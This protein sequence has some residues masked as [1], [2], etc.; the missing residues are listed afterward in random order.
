MNKHDAIIALYSNVSKVIDG[1]AYNIAGNIV[2][3]DETAVQNKLM[4]MQAQAEQAEQATKNAKAS[5]L[6]KLTALGLTQDEVKALI[7]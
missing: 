6:A 4:E 1:T 5:A 7:G 2:E 3:Y